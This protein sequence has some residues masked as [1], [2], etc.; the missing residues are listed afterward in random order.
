MSKPFAQH[1]NKGYKK[2]FH[3]S[4]SNFEC[5]LC[6]ELQKG[7]NVLPRAR[8][9]SMPKGG[10]CAVSPLGHASVKNSKDRLSRPWHHAKG[11]FNHRRYPASDTPFPII[12]TT[13]PHSLREKRKIKRPI[14]IFD[15]RR[16]NEY[17]AGAIRIGITNSECE[18]GLVGIHPL[19]WLEEIVILYQTHH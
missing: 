4:K 18:I 3:S 1:Q 17:H 8:R 2:S 5:R 9:G 10:I 19:N 14:F 15:S 12:H 11:S 6:K 13:P 7:K 16:L